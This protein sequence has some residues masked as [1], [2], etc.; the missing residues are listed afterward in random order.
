MDAHCLCPC[1]TYFEQ[2][3]LWCFNFIF[4]LFI[5]IL[6][7]FRFESY[8]NEW[9]ISF[10]MFYLWFL[11]GFYFYEEAAKPELKRTE[12]NEKVWNSGEW[13]TD[14]SILNQHAIFLIEIPKHYL[15]FPF[16]VRCFFLFCFFVLFLSNQ[17]NSII[18][19]FSSTA[20]HSLFDSLKNVS[21]LS[22]YCCHLLFRIQSIQFDRIH[23]SRLNTRCKQHYNLPNKAKKNC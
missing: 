2:Q 23:N 3:F 18:V 19:F 5:D 8:A 13:P 9:K 12:W 21:L 10:F 1:S 20:L 4:R 15:T 7:N 22:Y 14:R 11:C 16:I 6:S 17:V